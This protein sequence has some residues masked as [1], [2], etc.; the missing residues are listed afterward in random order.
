MRK[1]LVIAAL[2][3]FAGIAFG[4]NKAD[5]EADKESIIKMIIEEWNVNAL[6]K[7]Y[8]AMA[9]I[10]TDDGLRVVNGIETSGKEAIRNLLANNNKQSTLIKLENNKKNM[11]ISGDLATTRGSYSVSRMLKEGGD[12]IH[13][14][15]EWVNVCERQE[16]GTWKVALSFV[17]KIDE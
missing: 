12:T 6:D 9:E 15:G 7:N 11:W 4:Q 14:K 5:I 16:D 8:E 2:L 13:Y 17:T 10:Y 3:L 1:Q